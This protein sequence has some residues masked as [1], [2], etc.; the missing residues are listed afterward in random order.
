MNNILFFS[1][2]MQERSYYGTIMVL[3]EILL[4][5]DTNRNECIGFDKI[6]F[7][8]LKNELDNK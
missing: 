5:D 6:S 2:I 3:H 4:E 8:G 1:I 7:R